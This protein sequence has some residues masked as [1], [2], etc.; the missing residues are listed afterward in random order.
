[1]R[2]PNVT[3]TKYPAPRAGERP[4]HVAVGWKTYVASLGSLDCLAQVIDDN[5]R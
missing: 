5:I 1:M 4:D 2:G 3:V